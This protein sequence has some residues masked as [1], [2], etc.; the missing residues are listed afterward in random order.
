MKGV[1]IYLRPYSPIYPL[2]PLPFEHLLC[3]SIVQAV[4]FFVVPAG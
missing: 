1:G 2:Y 3:S 4:I